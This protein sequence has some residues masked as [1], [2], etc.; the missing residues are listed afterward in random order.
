MR[1]RGLMVLGV[2][3]GIALGA[4]AAQ[5]QQLSIPQRLAA[6]KQQIIDLNAD[7]AAVLLQSVLASTSGAS[8]SQRAWAYSLMALTR[9]A[10]QDRPAAQRM[11]RQALE[12]DPRLP[13]DSIRA[14][15]DLDSQAEAVYQQALALFRG[16]LAGPAAVP[17]DSLTVSFTVS[18][19]VLGSAE[20]LFPIT[21]RPS[22]RARMVVTV[23]AANAQAGNILAVSD[24]LAL[25]A[26]G[27]LTVSL[28]RPDGRPIFQ[29]GQSYAF[30]LVA[31]DS[32]GMQAQRRWTMRLDT[33][34]PGRQRELPELSE[35]EMRPETLQVRSRSATSLLAG[36]GLGAAA[37]ALPMALGRTELNKGLASDATAYVVAGSAAVAGIIGYLNGRRAVFSPQNAQWNAD[38]RRLHED[39]ASAI[40]AANERARLRPP[41]RV[42]MER[43]R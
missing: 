42:V 35:S 1:A 37:A 24:T 5:A 31:V 41:I 43:S 39:S 34:P 2:V 25:G 27:P 28:R 7:S 11:F 17:R 29:S 19:T 9:I 26:A 33:L 3:A 21:P 18:D 30:T 20:A 12:Q 8:G 10:A 38:R 23:A 16:A 22:R 15:Q 32:F 40:R 13:Q 6:A 4:G 14:L 36:V